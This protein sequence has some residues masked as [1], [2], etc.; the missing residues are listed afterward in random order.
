MTKPLHTVLR[1][2]LL[3]LALGRLDA[4][5]AQAPANDNPCSATV[6][7]P[8]GVLCTAPTV[9]TNANATTTNPNGYQN[10]STTGGCGTS[11]TPRDVW[12]QFTTAASGPASFGA[13]ITVTGNPAGLV[14]LFSAPS[15]AGPFTEMACS[16]SGASNTV[17]PRLTTGS[18]VANTTYYISVAGYGSGDA[19]GQFT[20]C[21]TNGPG[22]PTCGSPVP[23]TFTNTGNGN[24]TLSFTP[25]INNSAPF[26]VTLR[27]NTT[28]QNGATFSTSSSP[29]QLTGLAVGHSYSYTLG[30]ACAT[31]GQGSATGSF[32][33]AVPNDEPCNAIA[34]PTLSTACV[35]TASS[36]NGS[37]ASAAVPFNT[38]SSCYTPF[39]GSRQGDV[40]FTF[41]TNASGAGSTSATIQVQGN[42]AHGI[43]VF[44]PNLCTNT[45]FPTPV[46][47]CSTSGGPGTG[48]G[49]WGGEAA[50]L[51]L[52]NL[53]P[54]TTYYVA[55][56]WDGIDPNPNTGQGLFS[57]C[58]TSSAP[59]NFTMNNPT[60]F[61]VTSTGA[62][63]VPGASG[64]T[65][66]TAY[67]FTLTPQGGG[68][69]L[70]FTSN[71]GSRYQVTGLTPGTTYQIALSAICPNGGQTAPVFGSFT[72]TTAPTPPNDTPCTAQAL[73]VAASCTP[74][75]GT[76]VGANGSNYYTGPNQPQTCGTA[77]PSANV[78]Y[79][80]TTA[81]SGP[82][83]T[84]AI[85]SVTGTAAGQ[86]WAFSAPSCQGPFTFVACSGGPATPAGPAAPLVLGGLTPNTT[87]YIRVAA[88]FSSSTGAFTIC[89][90][91]PS[92]CASATA[93]GISNITQTSAQVNFTA[94]SGVSSYQVSY[95]TP[96]GTPVVVTPNPTA[97]PVALSNL[98]PNTNYTV[99]VQSVCAGG[100]G[101]PVSTTFITSS[102]P[103]T[104]NDDCNGATPLPVN[105]GVCTV[106][107]STTTGAT[108]SQGIPAPGCAG[109]T[110]ND[111]WFSV[112]VPANGVVQVETSAAA[113]SPATD[114]GMALYSGSCG[115]LTLLVCDDDAGTDNF[116][117]IRRT[118]L[119]PGSTLYV[120]VWNYNNTAA[121]A[122][123]I[124]AQT[125]AACPAVSNIQA[126]NLTFNT[127]TLS[128][129][130]PVNGTGYAITLT[131]QGG[132]APISTTATGSPAQLSG[133]SQGTTYS[134]SIVTS[135][136]GGLTSVPA[137]GS[138]TT[139]AVCPA[140]TNVFSNTTTTTTAVVN[141]TPPTT[142]T[143][144]LVTATPASGQP[145]TATTLGSPVTLTGL[146]PST[147]YTVTVVATCGP[148]QTS[149][150]SNSSTFT[151]QAVAPANDNCSGAIPL[152]VTTTCTS[153]VAGTVAAATQS[154]AATA[155][156][157]FPQG[158][159]NDVWYSFVAGNSALALTL[160]AQDVNVIMEVREGTCF[161]SNSI[162][163]G[164]SNTARQPFT[165]N[166]GALIAGQ[167][168]YVRIYPSNPNTANFPQFAGFT[169]CLT[170][171]SGYCTANLGGGCP[172]NELSNVTVLST[173]LNNSTQGCPPQTNGS[174]Y[175]AFP[176]SGNTTASFTQGGAYI[177]NVTA[178]GG[179]DVS[180]WVDYN[181]DFVFSP[182]EWVQVVLNSVAGLPAVALLQVPSNAALG[183]TM[184]RIR[185]RTAG[186]GNGAN[187]GCS[188][189]GSGVTQDYPI[190]I[191]VA[192]GS[193]A[194]Q[195]AAQISLYPNPAH[196][197]VELALPA[198]LS[199]QA[200]ALALYNVLG[201]QVQRR[202]LPAQA[203]GLRTTLDVNALPAGVYS[204]RIDTGAGI[205]SKR[206]VVE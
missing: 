50:P 90:T 33:V 93:L 83:S 123:G 126:S 138:F 86:L 3:A 1:W 158:S 137:T 30:A 75:S 5:L 132:G 64:S 117:L 39:G 87:Y 183:Q 112:V 66:L 173:P 165:L 118:G 136:G 100:L 140:P 103:G 14:R 168:Y 37:T 108:A 43:T 92:S 89:A 70:T 120:R 91:P 186:S 84:G 127:A 21:L 82:A 197:L 166:T 198:S 205:I 11:S 187:D 139:A 194:E 141:F 175:T 40:W 114:T 190:T 151:T 7:T 193:R 53:T 29:F 62:L 34:L 72:T 149:P 81:A 98:I 79:T 20:I 13:A 131:P 204:V 27:D 109:S 122:F 95:V 56:R 54:N 110:Y 80:I 105:N 153:P 146:T 156:C 17:A 58:A 181:H 170:N 41:R 176:A 162:A 148:G 51:Q 42:A 184:M 38:G 191:V 76:T 22:T 142:G 179:S 202:A 169:L 4:A 163:C 59:C 116:S 195:L 174:Y 49:G 19:P 128:F 45:P 157:G 147:N 55:V 106:L 36:M 177:L 145:I 67:T 101:L 124:C 44:R 180:A 150:V 129:S 152:T 48:S 16:G 161:G 63:I 26:V 8:N 159:V 135:C 46:V 185:S 200:S 178:G 188:S 201:Q 206:L 28:N 172:G 69:P 47:G 97:S 6:L 12:F 74:V 134:V 32:A 77:N 18:L 143:S 121:G 99:T 133:L 196:G 160:V 155:S 68:T 113:G 25:G 111:V 102:T 96:G 85:I 104:S 31:G 65:P 130:G 24:G 2:L 203:G 60:A 192:S 199:T 61:N 107:A 164:V 115:A 23:G 15:C 71:S 154:L 57:I 52:S 73:T 125:D 9:A 171:P 167:T 88:L 10:P 144:Y 94:A 35:P 182:S 119:T 189:F 78:W